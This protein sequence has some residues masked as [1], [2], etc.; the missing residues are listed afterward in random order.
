MNTCRKK[1]SMKVLADNICGSRWK[2]V[3]TLDGRGANDERLLEGLALGAEVGGS[4]LQRDPLLGQARD[5]DGGLLVQGR[6][7]V[8]QRD[9]T[10]ERQRRAPSGRHLRGT[11]T[12]QDRKTAR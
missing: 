7:V 8:Q 10:A 3:L 4:G 9:T 2:S 12:N 11:T 6:L 5:V 1:S